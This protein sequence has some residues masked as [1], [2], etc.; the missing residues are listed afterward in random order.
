MLTGPDNVQN[1][2]GFGFVNE[3]SIQVW[4]K[5]AHMAPHARMLEN[6]A[7]HVV[8]G[9]VEVYAATSCRVCNRTLTTPESVASGIGPICEGR[10]LPQFVLDETLDEPRL[11]GNKMKLPAPWWD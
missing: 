9:K 11:D 5:Q 8:K 4:K 2:T 6:L 7:D 1:Y 3:T 10:S